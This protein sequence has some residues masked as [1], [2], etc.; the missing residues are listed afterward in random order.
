MNY[1]YMKREPKINTREDL[2]PWPVDYRICVQLLSYNLSPGHRK[3]G[4]WETIIGLQV[5]TFSFQPL[6]LFFIP[7]LFFQIFSFNDATGQFRLITVFVVSTCQ[8]D[9][10]RFVLLIL[11]QAGVFYMHAKR[12]IKLTLESHWSIHI[13]KPCPEL[14][15]I[16]YEMRIEQ[17]LGLLKNIRIL[18][19]WM[20]QM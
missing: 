8:S 20:Y 17:L 13:N 1:L 15:L 19:I 16:L 12:Q 11:Q 14:A 2:N 3:L 6:K 5:P 10:L 4:L 9:L 18:L 7:E